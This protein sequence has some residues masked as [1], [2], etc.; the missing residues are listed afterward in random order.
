[1]SIAAFSEAIKSQA[2]KSW[3]QRLSTDNILKMS[4]KDLRKKESSGEF[5]SFYITSQTVSDI[6]EKLSGAKA[7]PEQVIKVLKKLAST[8]YSNNRRVAK[9]IAEPYVEGNALYYPRISFDGIASLLDTGFEE[10]LSEARQRDP[11]IKISDYFQ[12]GHVFG[13]FPKKLAE[14]RKSLQKNTTLTEEAKALLVG[15]LEDLEKTLEAEDLATSNLKTASYELYAKYKKKPTTYLVEMQ[16]KEVNEQA[17]R[18]QAA[19]ATAIR[20]YFNSDKVAFTA[21]GGI[22]FTEGVAEQK[23]K[24]LIE[25]NVF[26]L[27]GAK[28]SPSFIDLIGLSVV[29]SLSGKKQSNKEYSVPLTPIAKSKA[30]KIDTSKLNSDIKKNKAKVKALKQSV[31]RVPRY[32]ESVVQ[33]SLTQLISLLNADLVDR[34]KANMGD[35]NARNVLNLRTGRLAESAKVE[36]LSM[37]RN[38][39]ITAFYSYMKNPY[40]TFSDGGRQQYPRTRDP[41]LLISKSIREIAAQQVGNRLR[42]VLV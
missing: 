18:E 17:G 15:Y 12:R 27:L 32:E 6:I 13:I 29:E 20:K 2:L 4:A 9:N 31:K 40:A 25:D 3:F 37:S 34:V 16:L 38:G 39:M 21:S 14:T 42:A 35:G 7:S 23:L 26:K 10:V 24:R 22:K 36:R 5:N 19:L 28:G 33:T 30:A 41:K 8:K 1:M 11:S